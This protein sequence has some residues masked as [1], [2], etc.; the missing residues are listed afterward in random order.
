MEEII[1]GM[2]IVPLRGNNLDIK[3]RVSFSIEPPIK[4]SPNDKMSSSFKGGAIYLPNE[5]TNFETNSF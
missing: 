5:L 3:I 1:I 2:L 4:S